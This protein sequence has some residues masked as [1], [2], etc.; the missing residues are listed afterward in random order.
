MNRIYHNHELWEEV[1]YNMYGASKNKEQDIQK[2][3]NFFNTESLV[4]E[5]MEKVIEEFKYSCEHNFT[6][7]SM[8]KIAW[9]G[10]ASVSLYSN[11]PEDIV[12]I[13]WSYLTLEIQERANNIAIRMIERWN[14]CQKYI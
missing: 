11:I 8:N 3:I 2:V 10:Q 9:L 5:Y 14:K 4:I 7:P 12:R 6:N 1:K 13:A